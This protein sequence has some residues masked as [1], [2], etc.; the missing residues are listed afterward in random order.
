MFVLFLQ[1]SDVSIALVVM[2]VNYAHTSGKLSG[3]DSVCLT[4]VKV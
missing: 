2:L 3:A 1:H 4:G